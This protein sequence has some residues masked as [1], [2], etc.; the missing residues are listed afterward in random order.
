[1]ASQSLGTGWKVKV[2]LGAAGAAEPGAVPSFASVEPSTRNHG[3]R[4]R[5]TVY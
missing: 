3:A 1:M 5:T 2:W 4:H